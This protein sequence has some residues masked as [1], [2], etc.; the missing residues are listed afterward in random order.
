MP[1]VSVII[2]TYNRAD[3]LPVAVE[4]VLQEGYDV[5]VIIVDDGSTD[6]TRTVADSLP[7]PVR[8]VHQDNA[9][10]AAARNRG[11]GLAQGDFVAFHD[12]DDRWLHG[13][14]DAQMA[15]FEDNEIGWVYS[16]MIRVGHGEQRPHPAPDLVRGEDLDPEGLDYAVRNIGIQTV[17]VRTN[18][19]REVG[20]FDQAYP[21][22]TDLEWLQR[23]HRLS[24]SQ[25]VPRPLVEYY[26]DTPGAISRSHEA[27]ARARLM[28]LA[29]NHHLRSNKFLAH[30]HFQIGQKLAWSKHKARALPHL[31]QACIR[32][33]RNARRAAGALL[34]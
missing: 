16:D 21:R 15:C 7:G 14:L 29:R 32:D 19:A 5:E 31:M 6:D 30:Q 27:A 20:P 34:A 8:Y 11:I 25:R 10:A 13:K 26:D 3:T 12:S 28:L 23:L 17:V 24:P 2:P 1:E 22:F 33:P 9:G 4:S 18:I